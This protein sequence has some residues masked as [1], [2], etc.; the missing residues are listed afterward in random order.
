MKESSYKSYEE[1]PLFLS[2]EGVGSVAIQRI[3]VDASAGFP[4]VENRETDR[5]PERTVHPVGGAEY[6]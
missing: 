4:C 6:D 3:R 1:L 5:G 2:G